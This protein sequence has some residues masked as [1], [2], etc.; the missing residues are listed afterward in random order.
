[1][2][3][4]RIAAFGSAFA[5]RPRVPG[6]EV[7]SLLGRDRPIFVTLGLVFGAG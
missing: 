1:M 2:L 7:E 3:F 6:G 5:Q 4:L